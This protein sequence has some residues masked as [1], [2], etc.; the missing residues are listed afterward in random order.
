MA[1]LV[2]QNPDVRL[3]LLGTDP[4]SR[5]AR[6]MAEPHV[7]VQDFRVFNSGYS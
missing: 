4:F 7:V 6:H 3:G 2:S 5:D 1:S